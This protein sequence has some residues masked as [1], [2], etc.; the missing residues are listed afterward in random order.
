MQVRRHVCTGSLWAPSTVR[1][2]ERG[3]WGVVGSKGLEPRAAQESRGRPVSPWEGPEVAE[4]VW[5]DLQ[6]LVDGAAGLH[7]DQMTCGQGLL[8]SHAWG[9]PEDHRPR[10]GE[11]LAR[12]EW[13]PLLL[14]DG[15]EAFPL[16]PA[17]QRTG[18]ENAKGENS[19]PSDYPSKRVKKKFLLRADF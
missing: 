16:L 6:R 13:M 10:G 7:V 12:P 9:W 1:R 14:P 17:P 19:E 5:E 2:V 15:T 4:R 3:S 11:S 8:Q 18:K